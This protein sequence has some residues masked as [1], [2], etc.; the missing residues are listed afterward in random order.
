M[1]YQ[2]AYC[3]EL[4][5]TNFITFVLSRFRSN[6]LAV[7][8]LLMREKTKFDIEEKSSQF[9]LHIKTLASSPNI[10]NSDKYLLLEEDHLCLL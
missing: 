6:L 7:N 4:F 9:L 8:Q 1:S 3:G 5:I 10:M 2:Y